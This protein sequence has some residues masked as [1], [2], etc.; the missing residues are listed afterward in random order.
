MYI[1]EQTCPRCSAHFV[2][3]GALFD[4]GTVRLRCQACAPMFLPEGSP[5]SR[6]VESVTNANVDIEIWEPEI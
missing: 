5:R 3:D 1:K 4:I 6:T 2:V